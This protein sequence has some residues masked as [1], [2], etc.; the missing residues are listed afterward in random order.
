MFVAN[1]NGEFAEKPDRTGRYKMSTAPC[2][3]NSWNSRCVLI[4]LL[5]FPLTHL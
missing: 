5:V 3:G 4:S 1:L 2:E